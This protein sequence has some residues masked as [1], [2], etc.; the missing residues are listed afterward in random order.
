MLQGRISSASST[1]YIGLRNLSDT[2]DVKF[3]QA[4]DIMLI[5]RVKGF[6]YVHST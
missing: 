2:Y 5:A 4:F 3:E 1:N 6:K